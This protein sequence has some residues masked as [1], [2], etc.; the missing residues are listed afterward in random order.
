MPNWVAPVPIMVW[1]AAAAAIMWSSDRL[2][3]L[4]G[5]AVVI[6]ITHALTWFGLRGDPARIPT[7]GQRIAL[8]IGAAIPTAPAVLMLA[9]LI[10]SVTH[11]D[12]LLVALVMLVAGIPLG[13]G[14][15]AML[16]YRMTSRSRVDALAR[17]VAVVG[18][19]IAVACILTFVWWC[20]EPAERTISIE[21]LAFPGL[22]AW[23]LVLPLA[24]LLAMRSSVSRSS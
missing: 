11:F 8:A 16:V 6:A 18:G 1:S 19:S 7:H 5:F 12:G 14:V 24:E 13:I 22:A 15:A 17:V 21:A 9:P 3:D 20:I 10:S 23:W 4:V 2:D